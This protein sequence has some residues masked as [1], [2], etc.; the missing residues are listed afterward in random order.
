[1]SAAAET[2]F[3]GSIAQLGVVVPDLDGAIHSWLRLGIGPFLTVRGAAVSG[4]EYRGTPS[5]PLLDVAFAQKGGVQIEL[6]QQVNDAPS[7]YRD[8][9]AAGGNGF[10]HFGWFRADYAGAVAAAAATNATVLQKGVWSGVHFVYYETTEGLLPPAEL[11]ELDDATR[12]TALAAS[13]PGAGKLVE[14]IELNDVSGA[15]FRLVREDS[16]DWDGRTNPVRSLL[17][18]TGVLRVGVDVLSHK[19]ERWLHGKG[20]G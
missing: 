8:F 15:V 12:A 11:A 5:K 7:A 4:Y 6:I 9:I 1:M 13:R 10:H 17:S 3:A 2:P 14:L 20:P 18:T 19:V 16:T